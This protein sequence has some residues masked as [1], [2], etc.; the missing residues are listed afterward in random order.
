MSIQMPSGNPNP[1]LSEVTP[2]SPSV[3]AIREHRT[4]LDADRIIDEFVERFTEKEFFPEGGDSVFFAMLTRLEH[5]PADVSIRIVDED[6]DLLAIYIKGL[7]ESRVQ[8]SVVLVLGDEDEY[9]A[10]D[11]A[12]VSGDEALFQLIFKQLESGSRLGSGGNFPGS[13]SLA[14]RIVTVREQIA[15]LAAANRP[16]LFEALLADATELKDN[17]LATAVNPF[18][19]FGALQPSNRSPVLDELL[20]LHWGVPVERLEELLKRVPLS[21][22]EEKEFLETWQ[23]P[24]TF[25]NALTESVDEWRKSRAIDGILHTRPYNVDSDSLARELT[26][27]LL[28]SRVQRELAVVEPGRAGYEP[29]GPD[30]NAVVLW[31]DG[32]GSYLAEN[33]REGEINGFVE[34]EGDSFYRAVSSLLEPHER[35]LL[36]LTHELDLAGFRRVVARE[37]N[38]KNGGWFETAD[39]T[40]EDDPSLPDWM[41]NAPDADKRLWN[42]ARVDYCQA[43]V[44]AQVPELLDIATLGESEK[45][46]E[47]AREKLREELKAKL[48]LELD[49]NEIFIRTIHSEWVNGIPD[50]TVKNGILIPDTSKL[51]NTYTLRSLPQLCVENIGFAEVSFWLTGQVVDKHGMSI[52]RLGRSSIYDIVQSLNLGATYATYVNSLLLTSPGGEWCRERYAQVMQAQMRLD[53]IEAKMAGDFLFHRADRGYKW[54]QA[55][56]EHP[57][58]DENRPLIEGHRIEIRR[59]MVNRFVLRGLFVIGSS[60][61][62]SVPNV[63]IYTPQAPDGVCFRELKGIGELTSR[64]LQNPSFLDYLTNVSGVGF[65]NE[66][67]KSNKSDKYKLRIETDPC[68]GDFYHA[69]YDGEVE[70]VINAIDK[71]TNTN[72][73]AHWQ[74]ALDFGRAA[75]KVVLDVGL[76]FAPFKIRLPIAAIRS[77]SYL[78]Q[79]R[80]GED[81][82]KHILVAANYLVDGL[83]TPKAPAGLK[84]KPVNAIPSHLTS[85]D[86]KK[87]VPRMPGGLK[88]R[89]NGV[90]TGVYERVNPGARSSF[91]IVQDGKTYLIRYDSEF[92]TWRLIDPRRP[93]AYYQMP[94]RFRGGRWSYN[95]TIGLMGGSPNKWK[96]IK[97]RAEAKSAKGK[98]DKGESPASTLPADLAISS[99]QRSYRVDTDGFFE[100]SKFTKAQK[101]V[102]DD[103]RV[104]VEKAVEK[105][106]QDRAGNFHI[107]HG[108]RF[109]LD[110]PGVGGSTGRGAYRLLLQ[111]GSKGILVPVEILDPHR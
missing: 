34:V 93:D 9:V 16:L 35:E 18:L 78:I 54:V 82:L 5:W 62:Q 97:E 26:D 50:Y 75:G 10:Q 6:D 7:D 15:G 80:D 66:L 69:Q 25:F 79:A 111:R 36:G 21:D 110:L 87:N 4:R 8:H 20:T 73:E 45:L 88:L 71:Q 67:N 55:V 14:G 27:Q 83:P 43:M 46:R 60:S 19:P 56:V 70:R 74:S 85:L 40:H 52:N 65:V 91:Y 37:A 30:D 68:T 94:I 61:S 44:E 24:E 29:T 28:Q 100:S 42:T 106:H 77:I 64:L 105:F 89:T 104:A 23:L 1:S 32:H 90:F 103:L 41:K 31:H 95:N 53:A 81:Y 11:Q 49:P 84:T 39:H 109:S 101:N 59:L 51:I 107:S 76:Q 17:P 102:Q 38:E 96:K 2:F 72:G 13:N 22:A 12:Q 63:V 57:V 33:L 48:G 99:T 47:F 108:G 92:S 98:G 58:D 3:M 86:P